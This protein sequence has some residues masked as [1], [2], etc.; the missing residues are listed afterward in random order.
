[1]KQPFFSCLLSV[2]CYQ[3]K[4]LDSRGPC[5]PLSTVNCQLSTVNYYQS[6][7]HLFLTAICA[8]VRLGKEAIL[9]L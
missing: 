9:N 6:F 3:V 4:P 1:M 8:T 7:N 2:V 5:C